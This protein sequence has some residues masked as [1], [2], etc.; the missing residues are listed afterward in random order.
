VLS[1]EGKIVRY[2][3]DEFAIC[4]LALGIADLLTEKFFGISRLPRFQRMPS[5]IDNTTRLWYLIYEH[6]VNEV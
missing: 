5:V 3:G 6:I 1:S 4:G 2:H